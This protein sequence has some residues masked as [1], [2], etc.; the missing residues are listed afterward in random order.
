MTAP[1]QGGAAAQ[2]QQPPAAKGSEASGQQREAATA[3]ELPAQDVRV[4]F[5]SSGEP[6]VASQSQ[7]TGAMPTIPAAPHEFCLQMGRDKRRAL[8]EALVQDTLSALPV[9]PTAVSNV[10]GPFVEVSRVGEATADVHVVHQFRLH[11]DKGAA[12][13]NGNGVLQA[14]ADV[15]GLPRVRSSGG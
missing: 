5:A 13:S 4:H 14:G 7:G 6:E 3:V 15:Q 9:K 1:Q 10:Q 8:S 12:A 2:Q 11:F